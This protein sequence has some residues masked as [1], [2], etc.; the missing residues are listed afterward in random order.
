MNKK[1][2]IDNYWANRGLFALLLLPIVYYIIF[3]Y[4]PMYG[5]LI[6]FKD[7]RFREG[8]IGSEW[9]GFLHF[10]ELFSSPSFWRVFKNTMIISG[11]NLIFGFPA[12][13]LFALLLNEIW[14]KRFKKVVQTI[15]YL[16]H[17]ISWVIMAGLLM[18]LLSP[19]TGP[20]NILLKMIGLDPIYF[21][22]DKSWFR[23]VLVTTNIWKD[24]GWGSVVYLASISSIDP[25]LYEAAEIDGANRFQRMVKITLPSMMPV[26]TI[27]LIFAVGKI[28]NDNFDQIFNLYNPAVYNVGDVLSTYAYRL[29]LVQMEYSFSTAIGFFKNLISLVLILSANAIAKRMG[30]YAIWS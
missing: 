23:S 13:I 19:S 2:L 27:M 3:H 17:F 16:P 21:L 22:A 29:G 18:Q 26:I 12:P 5:V 1:S 20:V 25:Q 15:S 24:I 11:A 8:I 28:I 9:V 30:E 4:I 14:H 10:R 7:F 6:A